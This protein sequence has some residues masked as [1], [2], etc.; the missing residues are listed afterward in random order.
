MSNSTMPLTSSISQ[1]S[2]MK[3]EPRLITAKFG[4]G[5]EQNTPDGINNVKEVWNVTWDNLT[6]A[7][8]A[9]LENT[10]KTTRYGC[11]YVTWTPPLPA[12]L[13]I[14]KK[15]RIVSLDMVADS[16]TLYS[17]NAVVEQAFDI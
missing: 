3:R 17:Y 7:D 11:D 13:N 2:Q 5:Y 15:Y 1:T 9:T 4:D 8:C 12:P 16:G 6:S 14:Q 10:W